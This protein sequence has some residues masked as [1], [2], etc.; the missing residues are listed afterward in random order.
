MLP[1]KLS[2]FIHQKQTRRTPVLKPFGA[3]TAG[4][5]TIAM[6]MAIAAVCICI[7]PS[8]AA[9]K[10]KQMMKI[11]DEL[12]SME[13]GRAFVRAQEL[14]SA[15]QFDQAA[16]VLKSFLETEPNSVPGHYKYGFVLLQQGKDADTLEQ[17]KT[18]VKLAPNFV[19]GW[20]LLGEASMNLNLRDQAKDAYQ[21]ALSLQPQGENAD[22]IKERLDELDGKTTDAPMEMVAGDPKIDEQNKINMKVNR[23][24]ALCK[25]AT[26][27]FAQKQFDQGMQECRDA[28]KIAPDSDR[29]KEN[30]VVCLNNYAADCVQ[31]N[32]MQQ[33]ESLMKEAIAVQ[34]QGGITK[35]SQ[36]TTLKNY[37]ALLNFLGRTAEAKTI[38]AR[39]KAL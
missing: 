11:G 10:Q 7:A 26:D 22:I 38:E 36:Q 34:D 31:K 5:L 6:A 19:G 4:L 2:P 24:L 35:Q 1:S 27:H 29:I 18:C 14:V 32:R 13:A 16:S 17:A 28:L 15:K 3:K 39:L 8:E 9:Q 30:F 33:A 23:A 12:V 37:S 21:K 25:S 20:S